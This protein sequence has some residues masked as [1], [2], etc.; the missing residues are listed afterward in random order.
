[1]E[2][3]THTLAGVALANAFFRGRA[4]RAAVP[5]L[6]AASNL[7]DLD[8]LVHLTGDPAA[9]TLRRS[10]GHSLLILPAACLLLALLL[11]RFQPRLGLPLLSGMVA[12]GVGAHLLF[13]LINSFGVL[14]LWPASLWRPELSMVFIV[15]LILTALLAAPLLLSL[16]RALRPRLRT[17]SRAA[18]AAAAVYLAVCGT[19]RLLAAGELR[20]AADRDGLRPE[21]TYVF[22]EPLGPHRWRGVARQDGVYSLYLLFPFGTGGADGAV[23]A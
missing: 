10:F 1:M 3:I 15:D 20:R 6:A 7:P 23:P 14:L 8:V 9:V 19:G 5:I 21:F 4:G 17:L 22:P 16:P 2:N 12:A 18:L 11:R 13:D